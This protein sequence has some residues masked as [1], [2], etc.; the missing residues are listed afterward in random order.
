LIE[1]F[2]LKAFATAF[3]WY[4]CWDEN[5]TLLVDPSDFATAPDDMGRGLAGSRHGLGGSRH[6]NNK[7]RSLGFKAKIGKG[8]M[9]S[10]TGSG[11]SGPQLRGDGEKS[12]WASLLTPAILFDD[13]PTR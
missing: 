9:D 1:L 11:V 4:R 12:K 5:V 3:G 13:S 8:G 2:P 10:F 7:S 6:G